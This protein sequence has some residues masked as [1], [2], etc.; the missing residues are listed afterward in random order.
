MTMHPSAACGCQAPAQ[1]QRREEQAALV[2]ETI[3]AL[4][5]RLRRRWWWWPIPAQPRAEMLFMLLDARVRSTVSDESLD[6][7]I[8]V[9]RTSGLQPIEVDRILRAFSLLPGQN[10]RPSTLYSIISTPNK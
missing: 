6:W 3:V 1:S 2:G 5:R 8:H 4:T 7:A 9:I 10:R